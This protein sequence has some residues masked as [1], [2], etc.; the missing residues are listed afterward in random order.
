MEFRTDLTPI[1]DEFPHSG[2]AQRI[3]ERIRQFGDRAAHDLPAHR[4]FIE[5]IGAGQPV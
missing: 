5:R 4:A 3:F 2:E 1:R